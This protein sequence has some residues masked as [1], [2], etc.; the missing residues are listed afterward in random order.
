MLLNWFDMNG[1]SLLN[2]NKSEAVVIGTSAR[3]RHEGSPD[4]LNLADVLIPVSNSV[5]SLGVTIDNEL[6]FDQHVGNVC[7]SAYHH[8]SLRLP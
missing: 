3:K 8:I 7:K 2:A 4:G 6:L 1:L 5:K